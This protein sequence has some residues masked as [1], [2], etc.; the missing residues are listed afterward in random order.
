MK[1]TDDSYQQNDSNLASSRMIQ[2]GFLDSWGFLGNLYGY[3]SDSYSSHLTV[4]FWK[5]TE[6][7]V[8]GIGDN[9]ILNYS[10]DDGK[11]IDKVLLS[12]DLRRSIVA[13]LIISK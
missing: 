9:E 11:L 10:E 13:T 12:R 2:A 3:A 6:S 1:Q 5:D 7:F 4:D 8:Q